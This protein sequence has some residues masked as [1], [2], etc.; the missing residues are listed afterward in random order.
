MEANKAQADYWAS[1]AGLKWIEH[2]FAL[3][4]AMAGMLDAML[5]TADI[6]STD[7]IIDIGCGTPYPPCCCGL[8]EFCCDISY[9][10]DAC[11]WSCL[12]RDLIVTALCFSLMQGT[13]LE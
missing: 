12:L 3:D 9:V 4:T 8:F 11:L 6:G 2:E 7:R 1:P 13:R 10:S 5:D